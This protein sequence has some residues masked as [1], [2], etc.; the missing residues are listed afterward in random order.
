VE[1]TWIVLR[2]LSHQFN[3]LCRCLSLD[4]CALLC[5]FSLLHFVLGAFCLLLGDLL[6]FLSIDLP[7]I[8]SRYSLPKVR[9][10]MAKLSMMMLKWAARSDSKCLILSDTWSR[11][12][13][14]WAAENWATTVLRI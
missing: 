12:E 6:A 4:D 3:G 8:A 10:V 13:R 14:S 2:C 9:S 11:W 7:S 5:L 1:I